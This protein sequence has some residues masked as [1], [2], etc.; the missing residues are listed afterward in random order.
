VADTS[1]ISLGQLSVPVVEAR[2]AR[3]NGLAH[4][5]GRLAAVLV[6]LVG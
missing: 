2:L 4:D 1:A 5:P 6:D 3:P